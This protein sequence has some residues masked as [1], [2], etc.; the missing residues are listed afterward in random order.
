MSSKALTAF[1][2]LT[3]IAVIGGSF[4]LIGYEI[5][6][7]VPPQIE[8]RTLPPPDKPYA[9]NQVDFNV[10][11]PSKATGKVGPSIVDFQDA[12]GVVLEVPTIYSIPNMTSGYLMAGITADKKPAAIRVD[13][14]GRVMCAPP[15]TQRKHR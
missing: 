12:R 9:A 11:G 2:F 1:G 10:V 15:P 13:S 8:Y 7:D 14:Q 3:T 6:R 5:G 4:G